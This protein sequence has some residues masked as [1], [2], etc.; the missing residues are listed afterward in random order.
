MANVKILLVE[1][2]S[3]ESNDIK[4]SLESFGYD[5][6]YVTSNFEDAVRKT[7]EIMPDIILMDIDLK[8]NGDGTDAVSKIKKSEYTYHISNCSF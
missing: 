4:H 2:E 5:V 1:D 6:P 8:E 7:R 3:T